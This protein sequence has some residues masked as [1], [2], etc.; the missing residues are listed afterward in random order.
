[1]IR[2]LITAVAMT[3]AAV[4]AAT[5]CAA[6]TPEATPIALVEAMEPPVLI[7]NSMVI[8]GTG[9]DRALVPAT[10]TSAYRRY[11]DEKH[12]RTTGACR[13]QCPR[14]IVLDATVM[15]HITRN[16]RMAVSSGKPS[17][18]TKVDE[19]RQ[20]A[21]RKAACGGFTYRYGGTECDE[22]PFASSA[23][24]GAGARTEEVP[25]REQRCQGAAM[26]RQYS[27]QGIVP[28]VDFR[29][30]ILNPQ[31]IASGPYQGADTAKV[32]EVNC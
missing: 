3:A 29:V 32:K 14:V 30:A 24:G 18:L 12:G 21:N 27:K 26:G 15:P 2:R 19:V 4:L 10:A 7:G 6:A 5:G 23:E 31:F 16:I 28:G 25:M 11:L 17:R 20:R 8:M 9:E 22:Y 1:M 13:D